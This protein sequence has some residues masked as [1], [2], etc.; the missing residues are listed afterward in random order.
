MHPTS[1]EMYWV[2]R[3]VRIG[4]FPRVQLQPDIFHSP[5]MT[6]TFLPFSEEPLSQKPNLYHDGGKQVS[7]QKNAVCSLEEKLVAAVFKVKRIARHEI[8]STGSLL[9]F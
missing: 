9:T 7:V 8:C 1:P 4:V 5:L 3:V 2:H 6:S